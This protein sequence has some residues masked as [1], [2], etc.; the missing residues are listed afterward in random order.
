VTASYGAVLL[1][2]ETSDATEAMRLADQR[3]YARKSSSRLSAPR[4][5]TDVLMQ[6][7]A[8]RS[9]KLGEH[10]TG[11]TELAAMVATRLGLSPEQIDD[12][13]RASALHDI[14][15][16]AIPEDILE[17]PEPLTAEEREFVRQHTVIGERILAAAPSMTACAKIVRASHEN[18]D[19]TGY[20]DGIAGEDIPLEARIIRACDAFEA[21]TTTRP[22][23]P[24][25][26]PEAAIAELQRYAGT[27]FDPDVVQAVVAEVS[28]HSLR[29]PD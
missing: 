1:P 9:A 21:M 10:I 3:M 25:R 27:Q 5:T 13:K 11:V 4:Q 29:M 22:Y 24:G 18:W 28:V 6:I 2:T 16:L 23:Q 20:P 8:E 17:K 12:L 14:G 19:G 7:T 15:K 26:T